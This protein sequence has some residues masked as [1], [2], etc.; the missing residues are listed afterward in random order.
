MIINVFSRVSPK[1]SNICGVI[2]LQILITFVVLSQFHAIQLASVHYQKVTRIA[3]QVFFLDI[4]NN[5][6]DLTSTSATPLVLL[7]SLSRPDTTHII[8]TQSGADP[9]GVARW[10]MEAP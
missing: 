4:V 1:M 5:K 2:S 10:R 6:R 8:N 3:F 7:A 9:E